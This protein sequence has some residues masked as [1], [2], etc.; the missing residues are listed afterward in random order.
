MDIEKI[1]EDVDSFIGDLNKEYFLALSGQKQGIDSSSIF[2][3]YKHLN[4]REIIDFLSEMIGGEEGDIRRERFLRQFLAIF[5]QSFVNREMED[6]ITNAQSNATIDVD[7]ETVGYY[8]IPVLI[9]NTGDRKRRTRYFK[10]GNELSERFIP[11]YLEGWR[12][13]CSTVEE[14][15][16]DNITQFVEELGNLDLLSLMEMMRGFLG[17]TGDIYES[18]LKLELRERVDISP[19]DAVTHDIAFLMRGEWF[20]GVFTDRKLLPTIKE[21]GEEWGLDITA[22]GNIEF[23][24]KDREKKSP[25]AFCAPITVPTSV[26]LVIKPSGGISDYESFLHELG[27]ALHFGYTKEDLDLEYRRLGDNSVTEA[28]AFLIQHMML[29]RD[30]LIRY[31]DIPDIEDYLRLAHFKNLFMLRRYGAKLEY[32]LKFYRDEEFEKKRDIYKESLERYTGVETPGVKYLS[33]LDDNFYVARYLRAWIFE[34]Q[35]SDYLLENYNRDWFVNPRAREFL[36]DLFAQGQKY[37]VDELAVDLGYDGIDADFLKNR[38][39]EYLI[40]E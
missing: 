19:Q 17:E 40:R 29:N 33:D 31:F 4:D 6:E 11:L 10:A 30:W 7:N 16:Y 1:R 39:K 18:V 24:T 22:Y 15:G 35:L 38:V 34:A 5:V 14:L 12:T 13:K 3:R 32:E 23:D 28:Y 36:L 25:R 8:Q 21:W 20:D 2:E 27:H 9:Q 37:T 26:K